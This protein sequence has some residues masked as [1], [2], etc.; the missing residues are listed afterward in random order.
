M[1]F[2][3][4]ITDTFRGLVVGTNSEEVAKDFTACDEYFV[5]DSE[6]GVWLMDSNPLDIK[7]F[8]TTEE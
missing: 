4:Y 8:N 2:R 3:Y 7:E 5:V 6:T 1:K